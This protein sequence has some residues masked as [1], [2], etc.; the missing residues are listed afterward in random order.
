MAENNVIFNLSL[1]CSWGFKNAKYKQEPKTTIL[2]N[3][4]PFI[5]GPLGLRGDHVISIQV[6]EW[7]EC[8][9]QMM[10]WK[11]CALSVIHKRKFMVNCS[12]HYS[13]IYI[14]H[15]PTISMYDITIRK[16]QLDQDNGQSC[17][18]HHSGP[19]WP[20]IYF[21]KDNRIPIM[22]SSH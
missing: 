2:V 4:K 9:R 19:S 20:T 15:L 10:I 13:F 14:I 12:T 21:W 5:S 11:N 16:D 22:I 7:F 1:H 8:S 3:L 17:L 6:N 18:A